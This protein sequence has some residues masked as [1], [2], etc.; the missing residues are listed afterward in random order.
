[1]LADCL[2][3]MR[4]L[5]LT[6]YIPGPLSTLWLSDFGAEVVKVEPPS[7]DPM[8][9]MGAPDP[10]GTTCFYKQL[11]RNKTVVRIDL[12][13]AEGKAALTA[14]LGRAD[15]LVE[16]YRPGVLDRLGFD[17][18]T[19]NGIN[20]A[21]VHLSLSGYGQTGPLALAAGHDLT[22]TALSG[23]LWASGTRERP[24]MTYPPLGD[25]AGAM[26]AVSA[27][28][29]ALLR[30]Q[31]TG[32]GARL[33]VSLAEAALSWMGGALT[34]AHRHGGGP[35]READLINGGAACYRVYGTR[36]GRFVALAA[37]EE[38]FWRAFCSAVGRPDWIERQGEPLPQTALS[39]EVAALFLTRDRDDWAALLAPADCCFEPVL[40]LTEVPDH[41]QWV[42]RGL[43]HRAEDEQRVV[44]VVFPVRMDEAV[45]AR[46]RPGREGSVDEVLAAWR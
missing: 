31:R 32:R 34:Y 44:D 28:L 43:V 17:A 9:T 8:R 39:D 6:Q 46:R 41:P 20:P 38:K 11:N 29:A 16:A 42:E 22:Y 15:I 5:D 13:S 14:L 18:G 33:D 35:E 1:M 26:A 36:D 37:L 45:G 19:L 27:V 40:D 4:V 10:D 7:G 3:G 23:G 30:R 24:V 12:K 25:H 2:A 21:L